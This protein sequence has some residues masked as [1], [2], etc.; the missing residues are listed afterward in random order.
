MTGTNPGNHGIYGFYEPVRDY[1]LR[2]PTARDIQAPTIWKQ[3]G[4]LNKKSL[5][6]NM[7]QTYPALPL[8]GVLISGFVAPDLEKSVYPTKHLDGLKNLNYQIDVNA[9][10]ARTNQNQFFKQ[11]FHVLDRRMSGIDYLW[12]QDDFDFATIVFTGTDRL[13][14]Y[15]WDA[16]ED[17]SYQF[18]QPVM[19][20]YHE[21]D[22][23]IGRLL[24]KVD[25]STMVIVLSDHGFMKVNREV[26][27]NVW[28]RQNGY[29]KFRPPDPESLEDIDSMSIAFCVDPGRIYI[30]RTDRF[31]RGKINP[32]N[33][34]TATR[35]ELKTK[36]E[37]EVI[38]RDPLGEQV[39]PVEKVILPEE[40][41]SGPFLD[42]AP[43]LIVL[44]EPGF[45]LK[46]NVKIK[47]LARNDVLTGMHTRE[48]ASLVVH[49][50]SSR[51]DFEAIQS[52]EDIAPQILKCY[53]KD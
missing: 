27:L 17:E 52:I 19:D 32:G 28:L 7:P 31:T 43:D 37:S 18:H 6:V 24:E 10:L 16:V 5:I 40:I 14:H 47:D 44:A 8:N 21:I 29:L 25:D 3:L 22:N 9:W 4:Q 45:D 11:L 2:F 23:A 39:N 35:S 46:G 1:N 30:N 53:G 13:Q 41:Y 51:F 12:G 38:V 49:N 42:K 48:N 34:F 33:E 26:N 15:F 20:F 36:L 50:K